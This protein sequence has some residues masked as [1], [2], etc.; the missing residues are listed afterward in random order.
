MAN[1]SEEMKSSAR[2]RGPRGKKERRAAR[3]Q[4]IGQE[5]C[6]VGFPFLLHSRL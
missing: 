2:R 5:K 1:G 4:E 3:K 6:S